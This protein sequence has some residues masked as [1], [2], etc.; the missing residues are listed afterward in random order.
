MGGSRQVLGQPW[1]KCRQGASQGLAGLQPCPHI[2][3]V[4]KV[5]DREPPTVEA[6]QTNVDP[7]GQVRMGQADV[8]HPAMVVPMRNASAPVTAEPSPLTPPAARRLG[9]ESEL[10]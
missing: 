5:S 4:G 6:S 10:R 7:E 2:G 8:L 3:L 1:A 9:C